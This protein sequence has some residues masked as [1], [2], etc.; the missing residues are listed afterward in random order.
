MNGIVIKRSPWRVTFDGSFW[1]HPPRARS[2]QVLP[3]EKIFSWAGK[4]WVLPAAYLC[5]QGVVLDLC[6]EA[7]R[8]FLDKWGP[9]EYRLTSLEL[10][11]LQAEHPLHMDLSPSLT[12]NGKVLKYQGGMGVGWYPH[13]DRNDQEAQWLL[14]HYG[15]DPDKGWSIHRYG[16]PW[17]TKRRPR[18]LSSLTLT[19]TPDPIPLPGPLF[20]VDGP[21]QEIS[22]VQPVTGQ[23]HTL[24][25]E[26]YEPQGEGDC[27]E[28]NGMVY[29]T[30][31]ITLT[32]RLDPDLPQEAITLQDRAEGDR[33]Y[34]KESDPMAPQASCSTTLFT[35]P[36][37]PGLHA[38][39]SSLYFQPP[40]E[41]Q[42]Q[43]LLWEKRSDDISIPLF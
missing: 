24:T 37:G 5:G 40:K 28:D 32:Y 6:M 1:H 13:W 25:V 41:V 39:V 17:A 38:T 42:W 4:K 8:S 18:R 7:V 31:Y 16:F 3:L 35:L 33:P 27:Q 21:G 43:M 10:T 22:F 29:P 15:L 26:E 11:L 2:G 14:E 19:L 23:A 20:T 36:E 30:R 12:V 34:P 9:K